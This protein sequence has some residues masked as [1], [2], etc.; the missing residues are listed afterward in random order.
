MLSKLPFAKIILSKYITV[1]MVIAVIITACSPR[2]PSG[3]SIPLSPTTIGEEEEG[4]ISPLPT[5]PLYSPG[6]EVDYTV[7]P[8][9]NLP[10]L[11]SHFNT[12]IE[13]IRKSNPFLPEVLTTLPP[14]MPMKIPIYYEALWGSKYQIIPD[15]LFV[16]G[17]AQTNF[18]SEKFVREYPGWLK[19]FTHYSGSKTRSGGELVEYIA[20]NFSISPRLL[21]A[22]LEYQTGALSNPTPPDPDNP[23]LLGYRN[24]GYKGLNAQL[25]WAAN[26][27]NN[28][29]YDWR[30]G[31]LESY[32]LLDGQ[33]EIPDPWQNAGT[34]ALHF[35][36]SRI[37]N[38]HEYKNAI[39]ESGLMKTYSDLFGDPWTNVQNH[40][41]GSLIQPEF[42]L[43]FEPGKVWAYTGGPHSGWGVGEPFA[44]LDFA[45]SNVA[46]GCAPSDE[47]VTAV[48]DG[49][50]VRTDTA[51]AV[52]DLDNDGDERTGWVIFYLHLKT[53]TIPRLGSY[54][55][56]GQPIGNPSCE[57]G[58]STGTHVHIAR[59]YNGEWIPAY[60]PLSFNLEGWI[61]DKG[62][63]AYEGTLSRY[64][65]VVRACVCS[66]QRSNIQSQV[67][68]VE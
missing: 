28:A 58:S 63:K 26:T 7:Q 43:P 40:I 15:S 41:P 55:K 29:Y 8:G 23:Y 52:L 1:S 36:Y 4:V 31:Q 14:G 33:M 50:L 46:S 49:I 18:D 30:M 35:Y 59:K 39:S 51:T 53:D 3:I 66:D 21:L 47:W 60:G 56:A 19:D 27:L 61:S 20:T 10:A 6:E 64:N 17:P 68:R 38:P 62:D 34:V 54:L 65:H 16:N 9:D 25:V 22:M 13:E 5:R 67:V 45:A 37:L 57:G 2:Q 32:D 44:A 42:K 48:A 12:T 11:A 24:P